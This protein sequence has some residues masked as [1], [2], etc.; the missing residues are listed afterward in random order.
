MLEFDKNWEYILGF[1]A[2]RGKQLFVRVLDYKKSYTN[3]KKL[4]D[5]LIYFISITGIYPNTDA[6]LDNLEYEGSYDIWDSAAGTCCSICLLRI[7]VCPI[8]KLEKQVLDEYDVEIKS[9]DGGG[10]YGDKVMR[11]CQ[12]CTDAYTKQYW[13]PMRGGKIHKTSRFK[14]GKLL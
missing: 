1:K 7:G 4:E 12:K 5:A 2:P 10:V 9:S 13:W 11:I 3:F 6:V 14:V 8:C